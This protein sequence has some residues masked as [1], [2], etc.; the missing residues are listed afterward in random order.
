M[1]ENNAM[2]IN[3]QIK[4]FKVKLILP[5]GEMKGEVTLFEAKRIA[6][7][8]NL[9]LV[10]INPALQS[11][12]L[13]LCKIVD[14]GKLQYEQNKKKKH[15]NHGQTVKEVKICINIG[16]NDLDRKLNQISDFLQEK[17]KVKYI[18]S[19]KDRRNRQAF[20]N[21]QDIEIIER[22]KSHLEKFKEIATWDNPSV[23]EKS[24]IVFLSP[25]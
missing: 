23:V 3:D 13:P 17:H 2:K 21:L 19:L 4:S 9:D 24:V 10:E 22:V 25:V 6:T 14:Y 18:F 8:S 11:G 15:Q 1:K 7:E 12:E 5:N 20:H 16:Q